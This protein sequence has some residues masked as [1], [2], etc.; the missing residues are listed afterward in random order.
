MKS[1]PVA[2]QCVCALRKSASI[3]VGLVISVSA[4][5]AAAAEASAWASSLENLTPAQG[6]TLLVIARDFFS[7]D[8]LIDSNYTVCIDPYDAAAGDPQAKEALDGAM[9][10]VEGASRRMGYT[11]YAEIS[12][13]Y[14]RTRLSKM[15]AETPW[16]RQFKKSLEACLDAQPGVKAKLDRK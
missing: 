5:S 3:V 14:E 10:T 9:K 8:E 1:K 16:F 7:S 12:D 2:R 13:E 6:Q 15:L 11:A 4:V